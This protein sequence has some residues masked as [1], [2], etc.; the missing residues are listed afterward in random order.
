MMARRAVHRPVAWGVGL[1][2]AAL[3]A[4]CAGGSARPQPAELPPHIGLIGVRQ[5]WTA[6]LP[7]ID[8]PLQVGVQYGVVP[9]SA[10]ARG[11]ILTLEIKLRHQ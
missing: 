3:L 11:G 9:V 2:A 8:F 1:L 10:M 7:A 4:G 5:A 6:R